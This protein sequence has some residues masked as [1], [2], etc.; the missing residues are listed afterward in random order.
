MRDLIYLTSWSVLNIRSFGALTYFTKLIQAYGHELLEA[1]ECCLK[2][3]AT[4]E[5]AELT[6]VYKSV[7]TLT[8][9]LFFS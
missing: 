1:H 4:G 8:F 3:R 2:Y 9:V 6:K 7:N 5:D